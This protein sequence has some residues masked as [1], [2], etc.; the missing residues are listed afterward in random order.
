MV[1]NLCS[2]S[3]SVFH[4]CKIGTEVRNLKFGNYVE[5]ESWVSE[6]LTCLCLYISSMVIG[7]WYL[8]WYCDSVLFGSTF[9]VPHKNTRGKEE[10]LFTFLVHYYEFTIFFFCFRCDM[11]LATKLNGVLRGEKWKKKEKKKEFTV[12]LLWNCLWLNVKLTGFC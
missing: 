2:S 7:N 9:V 11:D 3:K 12:I 1:G 5:V 10:E 6:C 4:F 8:S